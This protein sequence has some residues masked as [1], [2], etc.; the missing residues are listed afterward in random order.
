MKLSFRN[1]GEHS[2][3]RTQARPLSDRRRRD[4]KAPALSALRK[5]ERPSRPDSA[6]RKRL[7]E[8]PRKASCAHLPGFPEVDVRSRC[9]GC[10]TLFSE[11]IRTRASGSVRLMAASS[12]LHS[13]C[14]RARHLAFPKHH[15]IQPENK[16]LSGFLAGSLVRWI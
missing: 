8:A 3:H 6:A 12:Q 4:L 16:Q 1:V 10:L 7:A 5:A 9:L 13:S 11:V 14:S 15:P 2:P